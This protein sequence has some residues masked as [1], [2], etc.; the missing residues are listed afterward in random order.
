M[1]QGEVSILSND[2][3]IYKLTLEEQKACEGPS[4]WHGPT[5]P[6]SWLCAKIFSTAKAKT[7]DREL[8]FALG[9]KALGIPVE[10]LR[11]SI[12]WHINYM[13]FHDGDPD[14]DL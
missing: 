4:D 7:G 3:K 13:R 9:A 8:A 5:D 12:E 1:F 2:G 6:S 10:S 11:S 14:Y